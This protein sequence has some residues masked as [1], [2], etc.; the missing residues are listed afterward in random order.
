MEQNLFS[1]ISDEA[2][3]FSDL[4]VDFVYNRIPRDRRQYYI[5]EGLRIGAETARKYRGRDIRELLCNDGVA[6]RTIDTPSP[7]GMHA[8]IYYDGGER[9]I[10]IFTETAKRFADALA[11]VPIPLSQEQA[12]EIFLAHEFYHWLEYSKGRGTEMLCAPVERKLLGLIPQR[13]RVHRVCEIA[14]FQFCKEYCGLPVHPKAVD[15]LLLYQADGADHE[16]I[17]S[18]FLTLEQGY[19]RECEIT[20]GQE[21]NR[22]A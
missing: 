19:R 18:A 17:R 5:A 4:R 15:Y 16:A 22:N 9:R 12:Q 20:H 14:A 6:I 21:E 2:F 1:G 8:Q 3:A 7:S 10:E 11:D 13:L